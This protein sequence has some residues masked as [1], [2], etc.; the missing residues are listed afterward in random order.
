[1]NKIFF[2]KEEGALCKL[3]KAILCVVFLLGEL[4]LD[5]ANCNCNWKSEERKTGGERGIVL[6]TT[7]S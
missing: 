5:F 4:T 3:Q 2:D 1:M 6:A 7:R